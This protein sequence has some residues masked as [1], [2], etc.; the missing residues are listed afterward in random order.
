MLSYYIDMPKIKKNINYE[1]VVLETLEKFDQT[2]YINEYI[3]N[4]YRRYTLKLRLDND[5][6]IINF[7][8]SKPNKNE[9]IKE[10]IIKDMHNQ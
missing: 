2:K 10:L 3:K 1:K 7:I 4:T 5:R 8:E 6:D 9:Y